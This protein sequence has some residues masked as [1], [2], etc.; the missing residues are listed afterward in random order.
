MRNAVAIQ[1][2]HTISDLF[3]HVEPEATQSFRV[4]YLKSALHLLDHYACY[5]A[6]GVRNKDSDMCVWSVKRNSAARQNGV[7]TVTRAD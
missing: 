1:C 6:T 4:S 2:K 7:I 3:A 5:D